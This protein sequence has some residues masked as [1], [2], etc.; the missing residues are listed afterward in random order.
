MIRSQDRFTTGID[1]AI[2]NDHT[3]LI[4]EFIIAQSRISVPNRLSMYKGEDLHNSLHISFDITNIIIHNAHIP[5][6]I[7]N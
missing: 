4:D 1:I 5:I 6:E 2:L 3:N 7:T